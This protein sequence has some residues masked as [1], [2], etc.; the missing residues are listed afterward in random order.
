MRF[1]YIFKELELEVVEVSK[2]CNGKLSIETLLD[3]PEISLYT[4]TNGADSISKLR[5]YLL[6][7]EHARELISPETGLALLKFLCS[8]ESS[9]ILSKSDFYIVLNSNPESRKRVEEGEYCLRTN[10]NGVDINRN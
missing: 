9:E 8:K 4:I 7:G 6:F 3:Q 2:T 1:P 10:E 5:T